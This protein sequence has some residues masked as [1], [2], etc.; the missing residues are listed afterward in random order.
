[1]TASACVCS[2][3]AGCGR[4]GTHAAPRWR[5]ARRQIVDGLDVTGLVVDE[6]RN[7]LTRRRGRAVTLCNRPES[8]SGLPLVPLPPRRRS[9]VGPVHESAAVGLRDVGQGRLSAGW[10]GRDCASA[11]AAL[12]D[13][14]SS[15]SRHPWP[16]HRTVQLRYG[17]DASPC[18][19]TLPAHWRHVTRPAHQATPTRPPVPRP[20]PATLP[21]PALLLRRCSLP[22]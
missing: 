19:S 9:A 16:C 3:K 5:A 7:P 6:H 4:S 21:T 11:S 13:S 15:Q 17:S 8:L 2:C 12:G 14:Q 1:M 10:R 22:A 20:R 18:R